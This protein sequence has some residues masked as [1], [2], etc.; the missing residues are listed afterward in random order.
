MGNKVNK[1]AIKVGALYPSNAI[2]IK[3]YVGEYGEDDDPEQLRLD[4]TISRR[5]MCVTSKKTGKKFIVDWEKIIE[6][7]IEA[8]I[9]K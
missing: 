8:G 4:I 1:N 2:A 6:L 5:E 3:E 7:A 9:N